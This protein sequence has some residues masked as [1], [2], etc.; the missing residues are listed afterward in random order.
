M[1]LH[2]IDFLANVECGVL[3]ELDN[4]LNGHIRKSQLFI[5]VKI[6]KIVNTLH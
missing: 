2:F 6:L 4:S 1:K 3:I 5:S